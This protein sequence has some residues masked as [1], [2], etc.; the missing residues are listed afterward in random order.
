MYLELEILT[1]VGAMS[2][3][4]KT[5]SKKFSVTTTM[6]ICSFLAFM[7]VLGSYMILEIL[8]KPTTG[9][10]AFLAFAIGSIPAILN[11]RKN[12]QIEE[13][14]V[15]T[16][17]LINEV[18][19]QTNGPLSEKFNTLTSQIE[20]IKRSQEELQHTQESYRNIMRNMSAIPE[21]RKS[22]DDTNM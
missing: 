14:A 8:N 20:Q 12:K 22:E 19:E 13:H 6:V 11:F 2:D 4:E 5:P 16:K 21:P 15:E 1:Q 7:S 3:T 18:K 17:D 9:Y 10:I